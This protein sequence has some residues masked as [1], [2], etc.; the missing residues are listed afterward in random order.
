MHPSDDGVPGQA[1]RVADLAARLADPEAGAVAALRWA[2]E[3]KKLADAL[4]G[5]AA[6]D[7]HAAGLSW[8][9]IGNQLGISRQAAFQRFSAGSGSRPGARRGERQLLDV[10]RGIFDALAA[11]RFAE[12]SATF[13]DRMAG[14]VSGADLV[15]VWSGCLASFGAYERM[16]AAT[17]RHN[18]T[19]RVVHC[20]LVFA[21][22]ILDGR[23]A[24]DRS[25]RIDGLLITDPGFEP[26][27]GSGSG[28]GSRS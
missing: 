24:L 4:L 11:G 14:R 3:L 27:V 5:Q 7:A 28:S 9:D 12:V 18:G 15:S 26:P 6:S 1:S 20:S 21:D 8:Q 13:T 16:T 22:G 19:L 25:R 10:A 2:E 17:V 23:I